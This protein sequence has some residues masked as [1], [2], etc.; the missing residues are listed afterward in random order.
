MRRALIPV[1]LLV[2]VAL[3]AC[4]SDLGEVVEQTTTTT[5]DEA[6]TS[7]TEDQGGT[8]STTTGEPSDEPDAPAGDPVERYCQLLDEYATALEDPSGLSADEMAE[9]AE[10]L[11][12]LS[13]D[14]GPGLSLED[15]NRLQEC[16]Q[17]LFDAFGGPG[18]IPVPPGAELPGGPGS[19]EDLEA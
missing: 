13:F 10:E 7:T 14:L 11:F 5:E 6:T 12:E 4:G 17:E 1:L 9:L 15:A 19:G 18:G 16:T 3:G 2:A 8:T